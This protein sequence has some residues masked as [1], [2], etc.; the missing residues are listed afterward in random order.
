MKKNI[1]ILGWTDGFGQWLWKFL[2][3]NFKENINLTITWR[4]KEKWEKIA[5][6]LKCSFNI[7]NIEA[8]KKADIIIFSVPIFCTEDTMKDVLPHIKNTAIVLDVT[9]IKGFTTKTMKKYAPKWVLVIPTHPMFGPYYNIIAGQIIVLTPEE[10]VKKDNR[11]IKLKDFLSEKWAKVIETTSKEHDKMMAV[12]QGLTHYNMFVLWETIKRL[13]LNIE[14]SMNFVSPIYKIMMSSV[15]RYIWH[16]P[17][18]YG[19]IQMYNEEVLEVHKTFMETSNDFNEFVKNKDEKGFINM[20]K[21]TQKYFW[22]EN[23]D[24]G[25]RYIDK[26]TYLIS[27]QTKKIKINMWKKAEFENIYSWKKIIW[28]IKDFDYKNI[29]LKSWKILDINEWEVK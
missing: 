24:A 14:K 25:Q 6:Q 15:S 8:S 19:D 29:S 1:T 21:W 28:V 22:K 13:K 11:Y 23:T 26:A 2:L 7:D 3:K 16:N 9:S 17:K 27:K 4:N 18:L 5:K 20:I 10:E 12:V